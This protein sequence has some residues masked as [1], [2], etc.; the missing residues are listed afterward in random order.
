M[1]LQTIGSCS[2]SKSLYKV[3]QYLLR[4]SLSIKLSSFML[5]EMEAGSVFDFSN[6]CLQHINFYYIALQ[7]FFSSIHEML[8]LI[9]W[10]ILLILFLFT[11]TGPG[12]RQQKSLPFSTSGY[13]AKYRCLPASACLSSGRRFGV[14][15][16][17]FFIKF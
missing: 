2:F 8:E 10:S 15:V 3:S 1:F 9:F 4:E 16:R 7:I 6:A 12:S 13:S 11:P 17:K 5:H 14:V